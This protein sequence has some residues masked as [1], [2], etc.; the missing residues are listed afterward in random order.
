MIWKLD[1]RDLVTAPSTPTLMRMMK[2][3]H[4]E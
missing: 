3:T 2:P 4:T 1:W